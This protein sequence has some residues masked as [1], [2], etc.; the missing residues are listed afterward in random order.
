MFT[1]NAIA[2]FGE[3]IM[4]ILDEEADS[5]SQISG[6]LYMAGLQSVLIEGGAK[7]L[8]HFISSGLWDE[9]RIFSGRDY[10]KKGVRAPSIRGRSFS[11]VL[12]SRSSM[13]VILND[14]NQHSGLIDY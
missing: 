3:T 12:F 5:A 4:V 7:V 14:Q 8:K 2:K 6:Y 13:E 1:H 11:H 10:F 9:A